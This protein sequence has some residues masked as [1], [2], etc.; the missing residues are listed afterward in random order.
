M[1]HIRLL[2]CILRFKGV[3][4]I[5]KQKGYWFLQSVPRNMWPQCFVWQPMDLLNLTLNSYTLEEMLALERQVLRV[6]EFDLTYADPTIFLNYFL[7]LTCSEDDTLVG[8]E[9]ALLNIFHSQ[10]SDW[11]ISFLEPELW[12]ERFSCI[13]WKTLYIYTFSQ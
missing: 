13:V 4:I 1:L 6:L 10:H 7:H 9:W 3:L 8:Q 12:W 11:I 2:S 5:C